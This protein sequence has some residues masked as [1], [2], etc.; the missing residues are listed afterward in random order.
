[1]E[2]IDEN[3]E[4]GAVDPLKRKT[5]AE[6]CEEIDQAFNADLG[7]A[8][9]VIGPIMGRRKSEAANDVNQNIWGIKTTGPKSVLL[10]KLRT[11]DHDTQVNLSWPVFSSEL[12]VPV[13]DECGKIIEVGGVIQMRNTVRVNI[14]AVSKWTSAC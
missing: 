9:S 10:E 3:T 4:V 1:M 7:T 11:S 14:A 13:R 6:V 12:R 2:G 5:L 8:W